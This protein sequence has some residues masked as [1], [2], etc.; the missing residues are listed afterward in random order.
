MSDSKMSP[1]SE[2]PQQISQ[3]KMAFDIT[4]IPIHEI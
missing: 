2:Y 4:H 1:R 3:D